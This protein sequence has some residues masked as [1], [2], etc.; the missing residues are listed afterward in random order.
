MA[1]YLFGSFIW[2]QLIDSIP[3][4]ITIVDT[5]NCPPE[6]NLFKPS[7]QAL[8]QYG[9]RIFA[10]QPLCQPLLKIFHLLEGRPDLA[11]TVQRAH[12]GIYRM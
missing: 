7:I 1:C 3:L 4:D 11:V 6:I 8:S 5:L 12:N 10:W 9:S 2:N